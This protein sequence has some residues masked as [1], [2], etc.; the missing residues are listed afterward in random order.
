MNSYISRIT[1][2]VAVVFA[3]CLLQPAVAAADKTRRRPAVNKRKPVVH[4]KAPQKRRPV[5]KTAAKAA[6]QKFKKVTHYGF[7]DDKVEA[8]AAQGGGSLV[9]GTRRAGHS[10]LLTVRAHFLPEMIRS[11][12]QL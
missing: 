11:A 8:S 5:K 9:S 7:D 3:L 1:K 6:P 12:E 4:K 10:S 2:L